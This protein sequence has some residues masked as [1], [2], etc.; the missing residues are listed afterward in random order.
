[1]LKFPDIML[2]SFV[3]MNEI[4]NSSLGPEYFMEFT[5]MKAIIRGSKNTGLAVAASLFL[6]AALIHGLRVITHFSVMIN[7]SEIPFMSSVIATVLFFMLSY[8]LWALRKSE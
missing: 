6:L 7:G 4:G 8:W 3:L 2:I 5:N 1:M